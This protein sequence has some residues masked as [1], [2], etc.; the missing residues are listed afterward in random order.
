MRFKTPLGTFP[1][2]KSFRG[3]ALSSGLLGTTPSVIEYRIPEYSYPLDVPVMMGGQK[4]Q[5]DKVQAQMLGS[6]SPADREAW[7]RYNRPKSC[8][9]ENPP[10]AGSEAEDVLRK[11]VPDADAIWK[12]QKA[13]ENKL[14]EHKGAFDEEYWKLLDRKKELC[15]QLSPPPV[16]SWLQ[17]RVFQ[18]IGECLTASGASQAG[19]TKILEFLQRENGPF[20]PCGKAP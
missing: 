12:E 9:L 13:V 15:H 6:L 11:Y 2:I 1:E 18:R 7:D 19:R 10:I 16:S 8:D 14:L 20:E 4:T 5:K 3:A 17:A